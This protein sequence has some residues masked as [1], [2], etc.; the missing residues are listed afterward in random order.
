MFKLPRVLTVLAATMLGLAVVGLA[1]ATTSAPGAKV[2]FINLKNGDTVT[3][4]FLV[5]FGLS[6]MGISPA[7]VENQPLTGHH[8]LLVGTK[9]TDEELKGA[10]P[11]DAKHLHFG[12]GQT[13]TTLTLAPG[14]YTLQLVLGDWSHVP[15]DQ[16]LMSEIITITVK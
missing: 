1:E 6:G 14:T 9:L 7:G 2:Y 16:P 4:P 12:K 11:V 10:I 13:E 15:H 3:S 5:Q 8:H